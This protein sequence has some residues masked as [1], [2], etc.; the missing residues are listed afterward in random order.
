[1]A[2][3]E[4]ARSPEIGEI[5]VLV[6]EGQTSEWM[7]LDEEA[8]MQLRRDVK[9]GQM[10]N[11][12]KLDFL[13]SDV[14]LQKITAHVYGHQ[15]TYAELFRYAS[16]GLPGRIVA[17]MN[18]DIVLR[19]MDLIDASAFDDDE[20][21]RLALAL[22][23]REATGAFMR[24]CSKEGRIID[25][26]NEKGK[27]TTYSWDGFVFS[28]PLPATSRYDML[29][30]FRPVPVYMNEM[31]A[32][33]RAKQFMT[34]SGYDLVNPCYCSLAEHWH[35]AAKMHRSS[36]RVDPENPSLFYELGGDMGLPSGGA[37][38]RG[39]RCGATCNDIP[40]LAKGRRSAP[41]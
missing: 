4:N 21:S 16:Y 15:P 17:L 36:T 41:R 3:G 27:G 31:G 9:D 28:S 35:C 30:E 5:R 39:I 7:N 10:L 12:E 34:A 32:E 6:D 18:A 40:D 25:R 22:T 23:V 38:T 13:A 33:N 37:E 26:C 20:D 19:N 11:R 29:E 2:F 8:T 24:E 1:M 14:D